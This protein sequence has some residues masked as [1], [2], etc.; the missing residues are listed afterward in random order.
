MLVPGT[1]ELRG[2]AEK[3]GA[4]VT[5]GECAITPERRSDPLEVLEHRNHRDGPTGHED[6]R[7]TVRQR[8]GVL[9]RQLVG[10]RLGVVEE[11]AGGSLLVE[12]LLCQP[13]IAAG[14]LGKAGSVHRP[15]RRHRIVEAQLVAQA[16]H[17]N[18][19][20]SPHVVHERTHELLQ[21]TFVDVH[22][23]PP[24]ARGHSM[25]KQSPN[26]VK[27]RQSS[28]MNIQVQVPKCPSRACISRVAQR[29]S[30]RAVRHV[31]SVMPAPER[32]I[33]R[34]I[35]DAFDAALRCRIPDGPEP[36]RRRDFRALHKGRSVA[37]ARP[38]ERDYAARVL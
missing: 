31:R 18:R 9:S 16:H 23:A 29:R 33:G 32:A 4:V 19:R 37:R 34:S 26:P 6:R 8:H 22:R 35:R 25:V 12:P 17:E 14:R 28:P 13:S 1:K 7:L 30:I 21:P 11:I 38:R 3:M 15:A 24:S 5:P 27:R 2:T 20:G 36:T 10:T